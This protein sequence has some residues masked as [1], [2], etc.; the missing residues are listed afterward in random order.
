FSPAGAFTKMEDRSGN[1]VTITQ[2]AAGPM[3]ASDGLGRTLTFTY[4]GSQ[5]TRVQ[6][7]SGRSVFFAYTGGL[8]SSVTDAENKVSNYTYTTAGTRTGLL[9]TSALPTGDKEVTQTYDANGR[10]VTQLD[11]NNHAMSIAYDGQGGAAITDAL[12]GISEQT[13]AGPGNLISTKDELGAT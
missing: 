2:G 6:D 4:T 10:V 13:H 1:A 5:L 12:G 3:S 11:A 7:Q 8:L 9:D